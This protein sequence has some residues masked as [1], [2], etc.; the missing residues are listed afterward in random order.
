MAERQI[1]GD[2]IDVG[3]SKDR[4]LTQRAATFGIFALKQ[5]AF[6]SAVEDNFAGGGYFEPLSY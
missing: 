3:W 6:A 2:T 5:M 4:G 1:L